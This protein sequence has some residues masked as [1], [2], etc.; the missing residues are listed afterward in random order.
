MRDTSCFHAH[1]RTSSH[2]Q[3]FKHYW[4]IKSQIIC[5]GTV[6]CA[7]YVLIRAKTKGRIHT[8]SCVNRARAPASRTA[9]RCTVGDHNSMTGY[10]LAIYN[11]RM[12]EYIKELM[13]CY[14]L[15]VSSYR[16]VILM[17]T[18]HYLYHDLHSNIR[19]TNKTIP[20]SPWTIMS[21]TTQAKPPLKQQDKNRVKLTHRLG[22]GSRVPR[23][24]FP[25]PTVP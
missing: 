6:A 14:I 13:Y 5:S 23:H 9:D 8:I 12:K 3:D 20:H 4:I 11:W 2:T 17:P 24:A 1:T 19:E 21:T 15:L 16:Y 10:A 18:Q 25:K 7:W 22:P